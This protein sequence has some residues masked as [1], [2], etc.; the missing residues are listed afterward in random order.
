[1]LQ[2]FRS[3]RKRDFSALM[4]STLEASLR[5]LFVRTNAAVF[6][7]EM[8]EFQ[9]DY[10]SLFISY[11]MLLND[12]LFSK[13]VADDGS[14]AYA[15]NFR[16]GDRN[17]LLDRIPG[18]TLAALRE[19]VFDLEIRDR[20]AHGLLHNDSDI[21]D[22][23]MHAQF[24][25]LVALLRCRFEPLPLQELRA[26][27]HVPSFGIKRAMVLALQELERAESDAPFDVYYRTLDTDA[28]FVH[29]DHG[30][31]A[32][33]CKSMCETRQLTDAAVAN[34]PIGDD[35]D[36]DDDNSN[37]AHGG[38]PKHLALFRD[39]VAW[40]D[41]CAQCAVGATVAE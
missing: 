19:L 41:V 6:G 18:D 29:E 40:C 35:D 26:R 36:D 1:M 27:R 33:F 20:L 34:V 10:D 23:I 32:R 25:L 12:T 11:A 39:A 13:D 21:S 9:L 16:T 31:L 17:L 7:A 28:L 3:G 30:R 4:F 8:I 22:D 38:V 2:L 15:Y 37:D 24:D 14:G 5:V